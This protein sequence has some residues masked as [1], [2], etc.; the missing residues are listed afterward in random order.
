MSSESHPRKDNPHE[1]VSIKFENMPSLHHIR[2]HLNLIAF[3]L[4]ITTFHLLETEARRLCGPN[5]F[6]CKNGRRCISA[7][8]VC[9]G[10]AHCKDSLDESA[11]LCAGNYTGLTKSMTSDCKPGMYRCRFGGCVNATQICDG[12]PDCLD[13]SD[14]T[15]DLCRK[16]RCSPKHFRC[17]YGACIR[18][19]LSCNGRADCLD[20]S[21]ETREICH[22][23]SCPPDH[24]KCNYGACIL[25]EKMCD[26]RYNCVDRSDEWEEQCKSK[27]SL[28]SKK[29]ST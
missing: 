13:G 19:R 4:I 11:Q 24:Y 10:V 8:H 15:N 17:D 20:G 16:N 14:E 29:T 26:K 21:D 22:E 3:L 28:Q 23:R 27:K 6:R 18:N 2:V 1:T 5:Q 25:K 12:H 9:D 7:L